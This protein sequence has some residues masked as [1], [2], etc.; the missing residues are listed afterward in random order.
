MFVFVAGAK[1]LRKKKKHLLPMDCNVK[2]RRVCLQ[3]VLITKIILQCEADL[4]VK[5]DSL[6]CVCLSLSN[7]T[8]HVQFRDL[9]IFF[10]HPFS[11]LL[12]L[13]L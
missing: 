8:P 9:T 5:G 2:A 6:L 3:L 10:I 13:I 12:M 4:T 7:R 11:F 1:S